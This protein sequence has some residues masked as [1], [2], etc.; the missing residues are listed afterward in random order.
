MVIT[1]DADAYRR[2]MSPPEPVLI[3][4]WPSRDLHP[5]ARVHWRRKAMATKKAR[6]EA[7]LLAI[8][9][10]WPRLVLPDGRLHLWWDFVPPDRRKRDDD[11]LLASV[12]AARDGIADALCIDDGRFVSHPFLRD[13]LTAPGG[14]VRVRIT[15]PDNVPIALHVELAA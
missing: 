4:P 12:K 6:N 8:A 5:N 10:R 9:A 2:A 13:D 15:T 1:I 11:G 14:E 7:R 3:L